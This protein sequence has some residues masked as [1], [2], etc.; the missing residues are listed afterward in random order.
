MNKK[1]KK[2]LFIGSEN[3]VYRH[4]FNINSLIKADIRILK[5]SNSPIHKN[6]RK[7]K[8][9][10]TFKE[11]KKFNPDISFICSP[12]SH[13]ISDFEKLKNFCKTFFIEKP[14]SSKK[15]NYK[16]FLKEANKKYIQIGYMLT[17]SPVLKYL[18]NII[19]EKKFGNL[20]HVRCY[21]GQ[22]LT[23]WRPGKKYFQS[24]S[25]KKELGGGPLYEL[26]HEIEY[27]LDIFGLPHSVHCKNFKFSQLKINVDDISSITLYYKNFF[28][29]LT[30]DFLNHV[31]K[32][33]IELKFENANL[34]GDLFKNKLKIEAKKRSKNI[35]FPSKFNTMYKAQIKYFLKNDN[36]RKRNK[37]INSINTLK[38]INLLK[39]SNALNKI[40]KLKL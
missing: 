12:A 34:Y 4:I 1:R 30:L 3:I 33:N 37:L 16:K 2:I 10:K 19:K 24:V 17:F 21:V 6:L 25:A 15:M 9:I 22:N 20:Y 35:N 40:L 5:R 27:C 31:K 8:F 36:I 26:S 13:H 38:I 23:Q 39:K 28:V 32:R 18:K 11:A 14:L 7:F 29:D